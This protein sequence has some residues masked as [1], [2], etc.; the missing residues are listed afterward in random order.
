MLRGNQCYHEVVVADLQRAARIANDDL[1]AQSAKVYKLLPQGG[2]NVSVDWAIN[3]IYENLHRNLPVAVD[4]ETYGVGHRSA[5]DQYSC[6]LHAVGLSFCPS[7]E[8]LSFLMDGTL[9]KE[10]TRRMGEAL[11]E[12]M[13]R[14]RIPK[15]MHNMSYDN[16]VLKRHGF[17][18][19]GPVYD[20]IVLH[21]VTD[22]DVDHDLA[23]VAQQFLDTE[24]W[25][26]EYRQLE[27]SGANSLDQLLY[28]NGRDA[29]ATQQLAPILMNRITEIEQQHIAQ[30]EIEMCE[31]AGRMGEV[32]IPI[33]EEKR[34]AIEIKLTQNRDEAL[35]YIIQETG[36]TDYNP[37]SPTQRYRLVYDHLKLPVKF[38]TKKKG[39]PSTGRRALIAHLHQ[40][41]IR[42]LMKFDENAK[43]LSTFVA[44][45]PALVDDFGR[46]H[47]HWNSTGTIGSRW[48]SSDP[49]FQNWRKWLREIVTTK[50]GRVLV[51][52]DSKAIEYRLIS[53]FAGCR[54][55]LDAFN[56]PTRDVHSEVA[57]SVFGATFTS[58]EKK[59][60]AWTDLRNLAKR[61]VYARNYR[62]QP[63]T[64][65]ENLKQDPQTPMS[66][67]AVLTPA[68]I[69]KIA[70]NFDKEYPEIGQWCEKQWDV[71]NRTGKQVIPPLGRIRYHS[72]IPVEDTFAA[73][74]I[75][76]NS[77]GDFQNLSMKAVDKELPKNSNIILNVHDQIVVECNVDDAPFIAKLLEAK[78]TH[79][80]EGPAGFIMLGAEADINPSW[81]KV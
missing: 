61:V 7:N 26:V 63:G 30:F 52:A 62:A 67:R 69:E 17:Q 35:A 78:M 65:C 76:Q 58:L 79:R 18:I 10:T 54:K 11:R 2:G 77:A 12:V 44:K 29:L 70:K 80:V 59:S 8:A 3:W 37:Q 4:T 81:D 68:F 56:D 27:K 71:A 40:P 22:P 33:H 15:I 53:C 48:S 16:I 43:L 41:L 51:G 36:W 47:P 50:P 55:L 66:V 38:Y 1:W 42:A 28:Y 31:L 57:A 5:L 60:K 20:T 21:H 46:L 39:E 14:E 6:K 75:P 34:R 19:N 64:I 32:G 23:F 9:G 13:G 45:L 72:V 25:K 73:N 24:P 74:V 49:N